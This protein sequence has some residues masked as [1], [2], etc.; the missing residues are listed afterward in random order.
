M[1]KLWMASLLAL[2]LTAPAAFAD[3]N[4]S[5]AEVNVKTPD[6][7]ARGENYD[8]Y[9]RRVPNSTTRT[10]TTTYTTTRSV[11]GGGEEV[12]YR[13]YRTYERVISQTPT[14]VTSSTSTYTDPNE[15]YS[16][17]QEA[18]LLINNV[19]STVLPTDGF[20]VVQ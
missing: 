11:E 15:S 13:P 10:T 5:T 18:D 2:T 8:Q 16:M 14:T 6:I 20:V 1:S 17:E 12:V 19:E 9:V 7:T 3:F 4:D